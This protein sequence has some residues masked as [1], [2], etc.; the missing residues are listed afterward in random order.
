MDPFVVLVLSLSFL[1][2]LYL[3]RPSP[4]RGKLP[5]GPTPLPI[6]GN[7]L[8][9]DMKDIRQ[10]ISNFSKTYGPVFTLYFGSQPTVVLHGYE[11]VK[12]ALIDYGEEFSGRGRMPV[13]EKA[14]KGLGISFSRGNVWRAT[15][16]FTVNTLRSL[17]MGKRTI[18]I[19]VQEEAEW[20]VMELKKTKGSP[21]DPKFIIGC[22]PCNVICSII[23]QNRFDYKDKD[24]LSL[25]ENVNEYIKIVSTPAFQVFNAF[26]ILLD[27]CPGNHKTHSKH[28]AAIKSY[29]L[30]KIKEHEE[31]LDVSNPRDFIDYFLIQRCQENGNQQMNYTQEH[32]AILVT[33]LFIGGTETSSLTLRFALLLLMK[34]P[35]ITDKVQEEIGQV[36]GRHRSPCMLDRIHMPYTNAMI[37]EVQRYIDLAPNGLLHEVTCDTKFRDYFI[38]KGTAVLTSLTSVLH[39]RKEFPN[40]EMFDPGHFLDENGN[41]KKS[42]YFMPFSAGKRKCVGEGLASMEL[43]LFLTTILQ[44]FKLKSLSDP[45]DIDIN[46]IRSEFS[47]IPPTFQLCFIP[48]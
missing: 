28:F 8:Q 38:P 29:L 32:L 24:F 42:D 34:Y 1:L 31:S 22:A 20:L 2:L 27:Y 19:K 33:N 4:G 48:V 13:F 9:I 7:F 45:K 17:G 12:E 47:S 35:H 3:W 5:P 46:S 43:F 37:H 26:P 44:N 16:H 14:T 18:E 25:I 21:C 10:S 23:F 6:F 40:P 36:I 39:A 41:F 11:A 30:K 15:R